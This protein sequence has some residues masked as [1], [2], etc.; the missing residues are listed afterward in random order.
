M[1]HIPRRDPAADRFK[2]GIALVVLLGFAAGI[3]GGLARV[4]SNRYAD[5]GFSNLAVAT[6]VSELNAA[7][8]LVV[9]IG[10]PAV[11]L[12]YLLYRIAPRSFQRTTAVLFLLIAVLAVS[13]SGVYLGPPSAADWSP[14]L[15]ARRFLLLLAIL[16][17]ARL[18]PTTFPVFRALQSLSSLRIVLL[19]LFLLAAANSGGVINRMK[20][21]PR[22]S[23]VVLITFDS[24]R[25]DHLGFS[26]YPRGTSPALDRLASGGIVFASAF[27]NCPQSTQALASILT[28]REPRAHGVR[29]IW[30]RLEEPEVSLAE[31]LSDRGY[32]TGAFVSL[33]SPEAG[34]G[35]EQGFDRFFAT[36]R[37]GPSRSTAE[38]IRWIG[39][40]KKRPFLVWIH[41][42][43]AR[44]PYVPS[45]Q[46]RVFADPF[47]SGPYRDGFRYEP[48]R[49]CRVFGHEPL[50]PEDS[51]QAIA[52]YDGEI[53]RVD[54]EI[55]QL[56]RG[57]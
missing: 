36:G 22:G 28:G 12:L 33:P 27:T 18:L 9:A 7:F 43:D 11:F 39:E 51:A 41:Y 6:F 53:R 24:I 37:S 31:I 15:I 56:V 48:T 2:G 21:I 55:D 32:V 57:L 5:A 29:R 46:S 38:A 40:Q 10:I 25:P 34:A 45:A 4:G 1:K 52:L 16:A 19:L 13:R 30:D 54:R 17:A 47:Y 50:T 42:K 49:A 44:M 14:L 35:L 8:F 20:N 26:G 3:L 23:N